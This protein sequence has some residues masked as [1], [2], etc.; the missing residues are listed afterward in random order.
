MAA[1][2]GFTK[3]RARG[4]L[5]QVGDEQITPTKIH[6]EESSLFITYIIF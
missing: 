6:E 1:M 2:S 3:N 4:I 5:R